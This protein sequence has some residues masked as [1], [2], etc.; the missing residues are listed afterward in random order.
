M[1]AE[2]FVQGQTQTSLTRAALRASQRLAAHAAS[3]ARPLCPSAT[4]QHPTHSGTGRKRHWPCWE[5]CRE[6]SRA[7]SGKALLQRAVR[8]WHRTNSKQDSG[9]SAVQSYGHAHVGPQGYG[10][11]SIWVSKQQPQRS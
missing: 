6:C 11:G 2:T 9:A 5:A 1:H 7:Q 8:M 3:A 4:A 10:A